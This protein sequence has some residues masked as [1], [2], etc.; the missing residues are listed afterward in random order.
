MW[1]VLCDPADD[2]ALWA[3]AGLRERGLAPLDVIAPRTLVS[4]ARSVHRLDSGR[5]CFEIALPNERVL[6]SDDIDGV[7]NRLVHVPLEDLALASQADLSYAA[8]ELSALVLSWLECVAPVMVNRP[9]PRG[10]AGA[11]RTAAEWT[12]LAA[13]AGLP[14]GPLP[15]TSRRTSEPATPPTTSAVV[16]GEHVFC[17]EP[18]RHLAPACGTLARLA[19]TDLLGV[20]LGADD[21]HPRFAGATPLPDLRRGGSPLIDRLYRHLLH[22]PARRT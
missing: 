13:T 22:L 1:L 4:S 3:G 11:W 5:A 19:G 15:L 18:V 20:D 2:A 21:R 8:R 16:V 6:R 9:D 7:L 17:D 10:T 14:V 12:V